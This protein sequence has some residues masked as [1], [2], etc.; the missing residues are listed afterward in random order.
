MADKQQKTTDDFATR[1]I[2]WYL[3]EKEKEEKALT[4]IRA[5]TTEVDNNVN[6]P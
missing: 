3:K 5:K 1:L 6:R 4:E 2:R